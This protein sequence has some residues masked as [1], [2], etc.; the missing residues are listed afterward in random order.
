MRRAGGLIALASGV[1]GA[2]GALLTLILAGAFAKSRFIPL[3]AFLEWRGVI[4][5]ALVIALSG[6][7]LC[8][9]SRR[10]ALYL[11]VVSL[12]ATISSGTLVAFWMAF[13]FLGG[14]LALFGTKR[15]GPQ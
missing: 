9:D 11:L 14:L 12:T 7:C 3:F 6:A 2:L 8:G 4:F 5:S 10:R 1:C 13:A 15:E